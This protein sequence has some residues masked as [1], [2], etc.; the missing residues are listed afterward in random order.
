VSGDG[1]TVVVTGGAGFIGANLCRVLVATEGIGRVVALDD[2]SSGAE[3]NLQGAPGTE[4]IVGSILE[5]AALD[6]AIAG[7]DTVVHL[8]ARPS[9]PLSIEDPVASHDANATGTMR[10]LE[11]L[12]RHG[13][14]HIVVASSSSVYGDNPTLPKHEDLAPDPRS[15]Y[16]ASKLAT[17]SY[18]LAWANVWGL[19]ALAF[20][21]FN[22]FG[23]LQAAGHAYAAVIPA[24][25]D[26]ALAGRPLPVHG[27]GLQT[28]DFTF[29]DSLA[30]VITQAVVQRLGHPR[31]VNLA[32]GGR[33]SLL[34]VI[35]LLEAI[36]GQPLERAHT[37]A[38][39]GDVRDSQADQTRLR[40]LFP[41][42]EP[43]D[44]ETGLRRTVDW[45]RS[46]S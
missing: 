27:D 34:E 29:V 17:E 37:E 5:D 10:V 16:A 14:G 41:D 44:L 38:R 11:A 39:A 20:R 36:L 43:L 21:F 12:R 28:R 46:A 18:T 4:L 9:V 42:L 35:D 8:A 30:A 23:P 33:S 26:A 25:V 22:V 45:F 24:F 13:V 32:F 31:P 40:S 15:P 19:D 3:A 7:A 2:L 1:A 6:K